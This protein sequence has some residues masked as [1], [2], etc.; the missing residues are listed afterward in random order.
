VNT[1]TPTDHVS[2]ATLATLVSYGI[3]PWVVADITDTLAAGHVSVR[4]TLTAF[5]QAAQHHGAPLS[6]NVAMRTWLW[7]LE[8]PRPAAA[9]LP[10]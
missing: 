10:R 1:S 2:G 6:E 7:V 5:A 4:A 8:T 3:P 9:N